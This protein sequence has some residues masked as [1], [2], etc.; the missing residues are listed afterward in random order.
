[1]QAFER[2][3]G[4]LRGTIGIGSDRYDRSANVG[5]MEQRLFNQVIRRDGVHCRQ[6][7]LKLLELY[8]DDALSYS[9]MFCWSG[10]FLVGREHVGD[11]RRIGRRPEFNIQL[12]IQSLLEEIPLTDVRCIAEASQAPAK[13]CFTF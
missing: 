4:I 3:I 10:Q 1:L 12:R 8:G 5:H 7:H 13:P 6:I 2:M 11:A 9:E